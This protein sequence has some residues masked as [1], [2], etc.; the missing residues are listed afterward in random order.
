MQVFRQALRDFGY[1]EGQNIG[2]E[3]R[4][5]DGKDER[6]ADLATELVHLGVSSEKV[7]F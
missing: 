1:V 6:A 3:W 5:T 4:F 2:V 7:A